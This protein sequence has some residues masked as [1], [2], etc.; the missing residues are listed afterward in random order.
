[1]FKEESSA[2]RGQIAAKEYEVQRISKDLE[3]KLEKAQLLT[4]S[5]VLK[6]FVQT[7]FMLLL[8]F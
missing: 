8:L 5:T 4:L 7:V 1:L 2:L 6:S 3:R